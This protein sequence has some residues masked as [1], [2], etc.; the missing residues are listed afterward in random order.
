[1][2]GGWGVKFMVLVVSVGERCIVN[3]EV[4]INKWCF[5]SMFLGWF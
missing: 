2:V 3:K 1:M 5:N 4:V